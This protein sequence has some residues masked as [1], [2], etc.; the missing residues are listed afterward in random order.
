LVLKGRSRLR[1]RPSPFQ[2]IERHQKHNRARCSGNLE[3]QAKN[4]SSGN[5]LAAET[6]PGNVKI[7]GQNPGRE[8]GQGG[9]QDGYKNV[10]Y[11]SHVVFL[12][13]S[14]AMLRAKVNFIRIISSAFGV[15]AGHE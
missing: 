3:T 7:D 12:S 10:P 6:V 15:A 4:R 11:G 5:F 2:A 14:E 1:P 13:F 9:Q 8:E